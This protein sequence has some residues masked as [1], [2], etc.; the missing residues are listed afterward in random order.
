MIIYY[1][2]TQ[3]VVNVVN[4][5]TLGI[6][7]TLFSTRVVR[8][9]IY[10]AIM[11]LLVFLSFLLFLWLSLLFLLSLSILLFLGYSIIHLILLIH[12]SSL[13]E[14]FYLAI[15]KTAFFLQIFQ[16]LNFLFRI[17]N[18][19]HIT[20]LVAQDTINIFI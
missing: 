14:L 4:L 15:L 18:L 17:P 10:V 16:L 2:S 20:F 19:L 13:G 1:I 3:Y 5:P 12:N 7:P 9:F 6:I 8:L 11:F